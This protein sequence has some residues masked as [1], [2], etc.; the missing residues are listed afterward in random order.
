MI[1]IHRHFIFFRSFKFGNR[2]E[3]QNDESWFD[4]WKKKKNRKLHTKVILQFLTNNVSNCI[5]T[6]RGLVCRLQS[7]C[8]PFYILTII[9][10]IALELV[11]YRLK[12]H[13]H[14][15]S[16]R[17]HLIFKWPS[18]GKPTKRWWHGHAIL[19]R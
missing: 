1:L 6:G 7:E 16:C 13:Y 18:T 17:H 12:F 19:A 5:W 8:A 14:Q 11:Q 2:Q 15:E 4:Y 3:N 10:F 9:N